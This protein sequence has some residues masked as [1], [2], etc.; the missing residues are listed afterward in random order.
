M[1]I[2]RRDLAAAA[3]AIICA[4]PHTEL[5]NP[6]CADEIPGWARALATTFLGDPHGPGVERRIELLRHS[7]EPGRA[8]GVRDGGRWVATLR[9]EDRLL[10]I[11][12]DAGTTRELVVDALTNVTVAATHRRRGLMAAM[13]RSALRAARDRGAPLSILIAAE[14]PIYGRFGYA[15][16]T[17]S[18]DLSLHVARAGATLTGDPTRV[19][20]VEREEFGRVA[21]A[22]YAV[23]KRGRAGQLDRSADWWNRVLGLDGYAVSETLPHNLFV[24]EGSGG[25]DGLLSWKADGD[26]GLIPPYGVVDVGDL[27]AASDAAYRDLWCYLTGIDLIDQVR[28]PGRPVDEPVR[29]LLADGRA[30]VTDQLVDFV[31]VRLLD[32]AAALSARRYVVP[33]E[34]VF[35]L[36]DDDDADVSVAG[37]YVLT[38]AGDGAECRPADRAPDLELTQSMLAAICLGGFN[39]RQ[40]AISGGVREFTSGAVD[41][42]AAMFATPLAPWNATWF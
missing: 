33:G 1:E 20:Q 2:K 42:F 16:A 12:G 11:P 5:V 10:S 30:L 22:V 23:A 25:P 3:G 13:L 29:W 4:M 38:A 40:L 19:R 28:L 35:E 14:W 21:P 17:L 24:H 26:V 37:R 34:L 9:T 31:W 8:W 18:A 41:R 39:L 32:V 15:P 36:L 27:V 7:W 6:V